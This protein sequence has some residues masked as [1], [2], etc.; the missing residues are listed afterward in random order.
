[1]VPGSTRAPRG[2]PTSR[3]ENRA[4]KVQPV[5]GPCCAR[6]IV[7]A[8]PPTTEERGSDRGY[9]HHDC[10]M[11][12]VSALTSWILRHAAESVGCCTPCSTL[13]LRDLLAE[14]DIHFVVLLTAIAGLLLWSVLNLSCIIFEFSGGNHVCLI[15]GPRLLLVVRI[16]L[17]ISLTFLQVLRRYSSFAVRI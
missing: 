17:N 16:V 6:C 12:M 10:M 1:M 3:T 8:W 15:L 2:H 11:C 4:L 9:A 5:Q 13:E 7:E 14:S